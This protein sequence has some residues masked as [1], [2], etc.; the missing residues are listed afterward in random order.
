M[1]AE[2][3]SPTCG[4]RPDAGPRSA[5]D[6]EASDSREVVAN[7]GAAEQAHLEAE[8]ARRAVELQ[9]RLVGVVGHDLR[10]PLA[11]IQMGIGLLLKRGGLTAE[12]ARTLGRLRAS[13]GRMTG[14]IRDL[15]DFTRVRSEGAIP[16]QPR[17]LDLADVCR[18]AVAELQEVHPDRGIAFA[19]PSAIPLVGDAE[20]LLQVASNLV[21]NALQHSPPETDVAVRLQETADEAVLEVHNSGAPIPEELLP[22][23]FEP[24]RQAVR[25]ADA[26]GSVGLGLFIV[27]AL[28]RAHGGDVEARSN[29]AEGTTFTV[30]LPRHL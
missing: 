20:R 30:R 12:Q 3:P 27:R 21:G 8:E 23:L 11:A 4:P 25:T 24:F 7:A 15:L 9:E 29:A 14:I 1:T 13:A 28:V 6:E 19:A 17:P 26:T 18:R 5:A 16:L 10:T 22:D 2:S